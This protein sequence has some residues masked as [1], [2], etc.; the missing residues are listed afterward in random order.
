MRQPKSRIPT[1]S[2]KVPITPKHLNIIYYF[3]SHKTKSIRV[4]VPVAILG[5]TALTALLIWAIVSPFLMIDSYQT[6]SKKDEKISRLLTSVFDYQTRYES[7]FEKAYPPTQDYPHGESNTDE[8]LVLNKTGNDGLDIKAA[9]AATI[10]KEKNVDATIAQVKPETEKPTGEQL[11][12]AEPTSKEVAINIEKPTAR[13]YGDTLE[14][15][16]SLKNLANPRKTE[17]FISGVATFE[18][19]DGEKKLVV[20]PEGNELGPEGKPSNLNKAISFSIRYY[21]AKRLVFKKPV[22]TGKFVKLDIYAGKSREIEKSFSFPLN[23]KETAQ[24]A[25]EADQEKDDDK[26]EKENN[27][28]E[29]TTTTPAAQEISPSAVENENG[30][31]NNNSTSHELS[32]QHTMIMS[33]GPADGI[34][35]TPECKQ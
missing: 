27:Q 21:K 32:N 31:N 1:S 10:K 4:S 2:R 8:G 9:A 5:L 35:C 12:V 16:L 14:V 29:Q 26:D 19:E 13:L 23:V 18:Q 3:D 20:T 11:E 15:D 17:G 34:N 25:K 28:T 24:K 6:L 33:K 22:P 30:A 7:V